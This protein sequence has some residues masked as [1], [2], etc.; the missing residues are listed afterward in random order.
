MRPQPI[1]RAAA[2]PI[3]AALRS[4]ASLRTVYATALAAA[5]GLAPA[6]MIASPAAA[7]SG[8][9]SIA[10]ASAAEGNTLAFAVTRQ[11]D[12]ENALAAETVNWATSNDV[13]DTAAAAGTDYKAATGTVSFPAAAAGSPA[14]VRYIYV[15]SLQ[16]TTDEADA[17]TFTVTLS[18]SSG[19]PIDTATATGT[20]VDDDNPTYTLTA[21]PGSVS[22]GAAD[23]KTTI[24]AKLSATSLYPVTIPVSTVDGTAKGGQDYV[25]LSQ[26]LTVDPGSRTATVDVV[27]INDD[28]DEADTQSFTVVGSP[29]TNVSGTQSATVNITDNDAAPVLTL[30]GPGAVNEGEDLTFTPTLSGLSEN[31]ITAK[32][33]TADGPAGTPDATHGT[34]TAGKDYTAVTDG[35]ITFDPLSNTP[36]KPITV[37]TLTDTIDEVSPED[38]SVKLS[39]PTN[40][41]LGTPAAATGGINDDGSVPPPSVSLLPDKILEGAPGAKAPRTFTVK[42]SK[43]SGRMHKVHYVVAAGAGNGGDIGIASD[44]YDFQD[45][46]GDL[47]FKPGETEKTFTVDIYG[48]NID[49]DAGEAIG[50]TLSQPDGATLE[51]G[52]ALATNDVVITDDD[53]KPVLSVTKTSV[54]QAEGDDNSLVFYG[55][56]LSNPSIH[57][58]TFLATDTETGTATAD[59]IASPPRYVGDDDYDLLTDTTQTITPGKT[60]GQVLVVVNG[61]KVFEKDETAKFVV[62][63]NDNDVATNDDYATGADTDLSLTLKNDDTA[64][65]VTIG[66]VSGTEGSSVDISATVDGQ[67]QVDNVVPVVLLDVSFAGGAVGGNQAASAA[68]FTNPGKTSVYFYAGAVSGTVV[69]IAT[70]KLTDDTTYEPSES[71]VVSGT[72]FAGQA[73]VKPG[74]ITILDN[75]PVPPKVTPTLMAPPYRQGVGSIDLTGKAAPNA[76][77]DLWAAPV[78]GGKLAKVATTMASDKGDYT[79]TRQFTNRGQRFQTMATGLSSPVVTVLLRHDPVLVANTPR[80]GTIVLKVTGDPKLAGLPVTLEQF[81]E[82]DGWQKFGDDGMTN[83]SGLFIATFDKLVSGTMYKVRAYIDGNEKLGLERGYTGNRTVTVQ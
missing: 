49:E 18:G 81:T 26:T 20:I 61:D 58:I 22:E 42:L 29:G 3:P 51:A 11:P 10:N 60:Y 5:I 16:D 44:G 17:E 45:T 40:A 30:S 78:G 4:R 12:S 72:A 66:S 46:E 35:T 19:G 28:I 32:W 38:F 56:K 73:T 76:S 68:D 1:R 80:K 57:P 27:I 33:A 62:S 31:T 83:D 74:S 36:S 13:G 67:S 70:V 65:V 14:Q 43:P 8:G 37:K 39:S 23:P 2:G 15:T 50:V 64:P 52:G 82:K 41:T 48:D 59:G 9:Y 75:D 47:T 24:T 79:F 34:A 7:T 55:V 25:P 21:S 77:V 6:I 69:P 71:I 53:D 63:R 54:T